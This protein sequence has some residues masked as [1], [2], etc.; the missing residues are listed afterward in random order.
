MCLYEMLVAAKLIER[1]TWCDVISDRMLDGEPDELVG[2][3]AVLV[4]DTL[5]LGSTLAR[6]FVELARA[7]GDDPLDPKLV[8]VH[9]ACIDRERR[10]DEIVNGLRVLG[11]R[12][13]FPVEK[14]TNE[15]YKFSRE[16]AVSLYR[17]GTPYFTDFPTTIPIS[18]DGSSFDRLL[19]SE[20][21]HAFDVTASTLAAPNQRAYTLMPAPATDLMYRKHAASAALE[22]VELS[23]VRLYCTF[24]GD[25]HVTVRVVPIVVPGPTDADELSEVMSRLAAELKPKSRALLRWTGWKPQA[26]HRLVQMYLSSCLLAEFWKDFEEAGCPR[27]LTLDE[28]DTHPLRA[29]FGSQFGSVER[30]FSYALEHYSTATLHEPVKPTPR[31]RPTET[32]WEDPDV[33]RTTLDTTLARLIEAKVELT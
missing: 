18:L 21:W 9:V 8:T 16:I 1:F 12:E 14:P 22:L 5:V 24:D 6:R 32:L 26:Q 7:V 23:K 29:Y 19:A 15:V 10:S 3:R 17:S 33:R 28:L 25:D 13:G 31:V 27:P 30:S 4:D 20:R 11:N 2:R